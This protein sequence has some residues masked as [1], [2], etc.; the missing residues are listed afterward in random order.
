MESPGRPALSCFLRGNAV[1]GARPRVTLTF[2][3]LIHLEQLKRRKSEGG[4][5]TPSMH[6]LPASQLTPMDYGGGSDW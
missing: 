6:L 1:G 5:T 4:L 3:Q 2:S